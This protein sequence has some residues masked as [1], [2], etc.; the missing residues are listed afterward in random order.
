MSNIPIVKVNGLT[1][2][3]VGGDRPVRAVAGVDLMLRPGEV[4]ALLGESGSGKSVTLRALM[5]LLPER[6]AV[7]RGKIVVDG[8]DVRAM[9]TNALTAYRGRTTTYLMP[10]RLKSVC[11]E[12]NTLSRCFLKN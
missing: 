1:V 10:S 4:L 5:R 11:A 2:D 9:S 3:F 8:E 12:L 6:R 7:I